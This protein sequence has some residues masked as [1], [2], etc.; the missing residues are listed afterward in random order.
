M[1]EE[2]TT[3]LPVGAMDTR[4]SG[5]W[6]MIFTV[7][8]EAALFA[9]LLFS[10]YYLAAQPHLPGSFPEGGPPSLTL[11]LPNTIILILSSVAVAWAQLG[12]ERGSRGRLVLGLGIGALL[13][14]IFLVV[15]GFE[16]ADKP[17]P[18]SSTPYSS[19][20]FVVTGF[21]M[22]HVVVGVL[23]LLALTW[24]SALGYFNSR[25]FAPIHIGALYWHFV[26]V[27]WLLVFFTFYLTPHLGLSS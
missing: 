13:G 2:T 11:A 9:Y 3:A 19:L 25:R 27:V 26:D 14:L 4:A 18:L 6:A 17:F 8:T 10:Y 1:T 22:A 5:W 20:Y 24:W 16:W 23:M 15:Q 7:F 21:H 12:I